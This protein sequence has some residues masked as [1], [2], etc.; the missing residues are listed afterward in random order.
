MLAATIL[1]IMKTEA[2]LNM[3]EWGVLAVG[4]VV[5]FVVAWGAVKFFLHYIQRH[6]FTAFGI[7]RIIVSILCAFLLFY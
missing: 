4:F 5:A 1:D 7:Y 6:D 2:D 3:N